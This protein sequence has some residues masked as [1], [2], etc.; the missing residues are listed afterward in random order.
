MTR[1]RRVSPAASSRT[2][3]RVRSTSVKPKA[4]SRSSA[5]SAESGPVPASVSSSGAK[6]R[7]S[8]MLAHRALVLA[9]FGLEPL[10]RRA[11]GAVAVAED[12][13]QP[14]QGLLV[15]GDEVR[16]LLVVELEAVLDGAQELVRAVE[17]I[18]VGAVDVATVGELVERVEGRGRTHGP[19]SRPCTSCSSC[20]ANS[21]SRMPPRPRLSSRSPRPLRSVISSARSFMARISRIASG[22]SFSGQT[23][24]VASSMKRAPSSGSPATGR[25]LI[26]AWNSQVRAHPS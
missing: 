16:L 23:R 12:A 6:K 8:W 13:G 11:F 5:A 14:H 9:V 21:M 1:D 7:R 15:G 3:A 19:S 25:A 17:A 26:S 10:A 4:A 2:A 22:S 24:G 18:D 20:T